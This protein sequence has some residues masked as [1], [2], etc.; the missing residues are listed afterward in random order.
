MQKIIAWMNLDTSPDLS[1]VAD[2]ETSTDEIEYDYITDEFGNLCVN[3]DS[4]ELK[5]AHELPQ[6][7]S[8]E[9][10]QQ[11]Y[12]TESLQQD[13]SST[14]DD[15]SANS[16]ESADSGITALSPEQNNAI[17]ILSRGDNL[18]VNAVAG[19]GKSTVLLEFAR[20]H[21]T[22]KMVMFTYNSFLQKEVHKKIRNRALDNIK[23][24]TYHGF[25]NRYYAHCYEDYDMLC[26]IY[27]R[28]PLNTTF[29]QDS[30]LRI[31]ASIDYVFVDEAQ[32]I[33]KEYMLLVTKFIVDA[34]CRPNIAILGDKYQNI[35]SY[36]GSDYRYLLLSDKLLGDFVRPGTNFVE[37]PFKC[38]FRIKSRAII[39]FI[40]DIMIG[41]EHKRIKQGQMHEQSNSKI[42]I[43]RTSQ[44]I[45]GDIRKINGKAITRILDIIFDLVQSRRYRNDDIFLLFPFV[46]SNM[47]AR[48]LAAELVN[49][50]ARRKAS[51]V[52]LY[53]ATSDEC[54]INDE[55]IHNKIVISTF[56]QAK[57][58]E[59]AVVFLFNFDNSYFKIKRVA[60]AADCTNDMYV[61]ATRSRELLYVIQFSDTP[62]SFSKIDTAHPNDIAKYV[63]YT[64]DMAG[65]KI[66]ADNSPTS[67][68][69]DSRVF[70][71]SNRLLEKLSSE[72][73]YK[74]IN[75]INQ[76]YTLISPAGNKI[77]IR[78]T[79]R[80]NNKNY[81]GGFTKES[82]SDITSTAINMMF[83]YAHSRTART[84]IFDTLSKYFGTNFVKILDGTL[85]GI[86]ATDGTVC[87]AISIAIR[88]YYNISSEMRTAILL[89]V[90]NN[91]AFRDL[92]T[93][94]PKQL[95]VIDAAC[96]IFINIATI[97]C[98]NFEYIHKSL[99]DFPPPNRSGHPTKL[100]MP[101]VA[102]IISSKKKS[103]G[104]GLLYENVIQ[105]ITRRVNVSEP[106]DFE[107]RIGAS[108]HGV[109]LVGAI[110][111]IDSDTIWEIKCVSEITVTHKFQLML[112][113]YIIYLNGG[114]SNGGDPDYIN[115]YNELATSRVFK[116]YNA[117]TD[118]VHQ[119]RYN[120]EHACAILDNIFA[121]V[122]AE[123]SDEEFVRGFA[124]SV[125]KYILPV[126]APTA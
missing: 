113:A 118:E 1:L 117:R 3:D 34:Q 61:A 110:D 87:N 75:L 64:T 28:T 115:Y 99:T 76:M 41:R 89:F 126:S 27:N 96:N 55:I 81:E 122:P 35:Y 125:K 102:N 36:S 92:L 123:L 109:R 114:G 7:Y 65:Y 20:L 62:I 12:S 17:K 121:S 91:D 53:I 23:I 6:D 8:S 50:R 30:L 37:Q 68:L 39:W 42:E 2:I 44:F 72:D 18:I 63:N 94:D 25:A 84:Y 14:S 59:R 31:G 93:R 73:L 78:D 105:N 21:P 80:I 19:S 45:D 74:N 107:F 77:K 26:I 95:D 52:D 111:I 43:I 16:S 4:A 79:L 47:F 29:A 104:C 103:A 98:D 5:L 10:L 33:R 48:L 13:Y 82:S 40:N 49:T 66:K 38:T 116:L 119:L 67:R 88:D 11:D 9:S 54:A 56:H 100:N 32:D 85:V 58:R 97:Y 108:S 24:F 101:R 124:D 51:Y 22:K 106:L 57:G 90:R 83:E 46:R 86:S 112:Y 70:V 69:S 120:H 60:P 15:Q 71:A